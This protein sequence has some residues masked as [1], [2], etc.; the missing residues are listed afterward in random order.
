MGQEGPP[1][2]M[3]LP[4]VRSPVPS[5]YKFTCDMPYDSVED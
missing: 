3:R 1:P 4:R 2:Q 5:D